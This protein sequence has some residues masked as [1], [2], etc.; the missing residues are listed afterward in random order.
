MQFRLQKSMP[1]SLFR[2]L[3][4]IGAFALI[5]LVVLHLISGII[6]ERQSY[7]DQVAD[8]IASS[9]TGQQKMVGPLLV[10][11]Y[12]IVR[13]IDKWF[14]EDG[15]R[16]STSDKV[17][18]E[19]A[20]YFLPE[21]LT[22][23]A[24]ADTQFRHR[25]LYSV[26]VYVSDLKI[27]AR[28]EVSNAVEIDDEKASVE[29]GTPFLVFGVQDIRGIN[30]TPEVV[31]N[32]EAI[33][34]RPGTNVRFLKQGVH[35]T[36]KPLPDEPQHWKVDMSLSL[37]GMKQLSFLP[38]GRSSSV[39][40]ASPWPHPSFVGRYLPKSRQVSDAGF[41][42]S[43]Q[44]THFSSNMGQDF[45]NCALRRKC[46]DF[47]SNQFGVQLQSGV[48]VYVQSDRA[49]KYALLFVGLTFVAFFMFEILKDLRIHPIQYGLVG[50][51]LALFY[52]LLLSL[53]EHVE[54]VLS[55]VI[56]AA[57]CAGLIGFYVSAVL[58]SVR[59]GT[60]FGAGLAAL[61]AALF[62][63]IGSEDYALVMGSALIFVVLAVIMIVT[64]NVDW[65]AIGKGEDTPPAPSPEPQPAD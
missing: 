63:L 56:A 19:K 43:W 45:E 59:R 65:H 24:I 7:R 25:G 58:G 28:F 8:S 40:L 54:F 47:L 49:I 6:E 10:A 15:K 3:L 51:A 1:F 62:I 64:R 35:A 26:P 13:N 34:I 2:K 55:Y 22:V 41:E 50:F 20:K 38:T 16:I 44:T 27:A 53:S 36:L 30:K 37:Q 57:A 5:L 4:A 29:W 11:P 42:A 21:S 39:T 9:W 32:G 61:Y 12:K 46:M 48:D 23:N 60:G 33:D 14:Y 31:V 52:L 17:V 18:T